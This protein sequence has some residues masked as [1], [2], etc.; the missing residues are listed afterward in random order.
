MAVGDTV[1]VLASRLTALLA[2]VALAV[3]GAVSG[4]ATHR[5]AT[6]PMPLPASAVPVAATS[7][8]GRLFTDYLWSPDTD[9]SVHVGLY[10]DCTGQSPLTHS[11][12]AID[13]CVTGEG[14]YFVGHDL[15]GLFAGLLDLRVGDSIYWY[16]AEGQLTEY[17]VYSLLTVASNQ[18]GYVPGSAATFQTCTNVTGLVDRLVVVS[19]PPARHLGIAVNRPSG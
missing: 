14:P 1:R 7:A 9:L 15:P 16:N 2:V 12:V 11:E 6:V 5:P 17:Q 19:S 4:P 18:V 3:V 8:L 13:S 10:G